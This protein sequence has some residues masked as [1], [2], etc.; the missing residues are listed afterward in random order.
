[1]AYVLEQYNHNHQEDK[2]WMCFRPKD[3]VSKEGTAKEETK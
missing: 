3:G 1:M 2:N